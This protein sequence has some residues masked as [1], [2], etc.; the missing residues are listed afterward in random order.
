MIAAIDD[1]MLELFVSWRVP[2]LNAPIAELSTACS[3]RFIIA[4]SL[5]FLVLSFAAGYRWAKQCLYV[6]LALGIAQIIT[7]FAK[8]VFDR[9]RPP[10]VFHLVMTHD[11][12]FPS[13]HATVAGALAGAITMVVRVRGDK[14]ASASALCVVMWTWALFMATARLYLGVHWL[15]DVLTG[16]VLGALVS[17]LVWHAGKQYFQPS[18]NYVGDVG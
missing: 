1:Y 8:S 2:A 18:S 15:S 12:S 5:V 14:R 16:L 10:E 13:G 9:P 17:I 4:G 11:A 3:P 7:T 6:V